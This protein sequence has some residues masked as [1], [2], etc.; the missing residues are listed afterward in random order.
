M[1]EFAN[2]LQGTIL[3][4]DNDGLEGLEVLTARSLYKQAEQGGV[5]INPEDIPELIGLADMVHME[6]LRKLID[7][8]VKDKETAEKLKP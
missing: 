5:S 4:R 8:V 3:D 7:D 2:I 1:E 6:K